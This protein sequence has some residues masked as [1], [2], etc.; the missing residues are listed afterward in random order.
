[1]LASVYSFAMLLGVQSARPEP[2]PRKQNPILDA[3]PAMKKL[4][5]VLIVVL[6]VLGAAYFILTFFVGSLVT[7]AVNRFGP[8][9]AGTTVTLSSAQISPFSGAGT[10][11]GLVV[12]NPPGWGSGDAITLHRIHVAA[13]ASSLLGDHVVIKDLEI[14]EPHFLYET[15]F[16]SSNIGDLVKHIEGNGSNPQAQA[17]TSSGQA[18]RFEIDHLVIKGGQITLSVGGAPGI[19]V[20]MPTFEFNDIGKS[21]GGVTSG[22]LAAAV[23]ENILD[24]VAKSAVQAIGKVSRTGTGAASDL[25]HNLFKH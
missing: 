4:G 14:D 20:P 9:L 15:K 16:V 17:K 19:V 7:T 6:A 2:R 24:S 25:L 21:Q 10:L 12:G 18:K 8:S 11:D 5:I 23:A 22:Q 13:V 1:M 3:P